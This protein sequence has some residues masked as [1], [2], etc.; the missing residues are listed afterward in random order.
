MVHRGTSSRA[1]C[2][3]SLC[4]EDQVPMTRSC[5]LMPFYLQSK[6]FTCHEI[7]KAGPCHDGYLAIHEATTE[8]VCSESLPYAIFDR[9]RLCASG[10]R[11]NTEGRCRD[12][13]AGARIPGGAYSNVPTLK[14]GNYGNGEI[15]PEGYHYVSEEDSCIN[16]TSGVWHDACDSS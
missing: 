6:R 9:L 4:G 2:V 7:G 15:C 5:T 8:V 16:T 14:P 1:E 11:R 12:M 13:V 3:R 10:S